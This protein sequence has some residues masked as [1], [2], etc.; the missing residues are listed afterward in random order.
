MET[1]VTVIDPNILLTLV[2]VISVE[3]IG[4]CQLS[5]NWLK[6]TKKKMAFVSVLFCVLC[7]FMNTKYVPAIHSATFNLIVMSIAITQ[8]G[9]E[10]ILQ[11]IPKI[12]SSMI[13]KISG[14][15]KGAV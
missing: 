9:Y 4:L 10:C 3:V 14:D 11:G 13:N 2:G 1:F 6:C 8:L 15:T 7:S 12:I 5:K